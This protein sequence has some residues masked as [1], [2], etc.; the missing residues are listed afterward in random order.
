MCFCYAKTLP[1]GRKTGLRHRF[2]FI[3]M[4][5][6]SRETVPV[7]CDLPGSGL[8]PT[9]PRGNSGPGTPAAGCSSPDLSKR[10]A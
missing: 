2:P 1:F 4:V 9:A 5:G 8:C 6:I 10:P 3:R 7:S